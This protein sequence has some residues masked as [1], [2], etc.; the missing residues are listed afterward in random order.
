M[1][2]LF[3][4]APLLAFSCA[5]APA[6]AQPVCGQTVQMYVALMEDYGEHRQS[7]G[8]SSDGAALIEAWGNAT[9]AAG[10]SCVILSGQNF[11]VTPVIDG[12]PA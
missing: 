8:L 4:I 5:A 11:A 12:D 3:L 1:T 2:K 9:A 6:T 10:V 7:L